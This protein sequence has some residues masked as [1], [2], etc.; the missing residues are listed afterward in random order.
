MDDREIRLRIHQELTRHIGRGRAIDM[1]ELYLLA[2]D[3][4]PASKI[5]ATRRLRK[6]LTAMRHEGV[7]IC[8]ASTTDGGGYYLAQ[9]GSELEDYL[10]RLHGRA[11]RIL[12]QEARLRKITLPELLGQM[13]LRL[14]NP[15]DPVG[16]RCTCPDE[17]GTCNVPLREAP[18]APD[19]A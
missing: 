6:I 9:A 10:A 5:N 13:R 15:P 11:L 2:F 1:S 4:R 3:Q 7:P 16:A 12:V 8:S 14:T 17:E 19:A 18:D